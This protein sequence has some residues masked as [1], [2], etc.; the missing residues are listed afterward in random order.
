MGNAPDPLKS[1]SALLPMRQRLEKESGTH[2]GRFGN[3][4]LRDRPHQLPDRTA[5]VAFYEATDGPNWDENSRWLTDAP[6]EEWWGVTVNAKGRVCELS[7]SGNR[8]AGELPSELC[9]LAELCVLNLED[10]EL[11]G[12]VPSSCVTSPVW[13]LWILRITR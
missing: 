5:L 10:N 6:L 12:P 13:L 2:G 9:G 7:L 3:L 8:L 11:S 4:I 1:P